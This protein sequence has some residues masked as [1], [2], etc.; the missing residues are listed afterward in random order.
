MTIFVPLMCTFHKTSQVYLTVL[1]KYMNC[2][3]KLNGEKIE[4]DKIK[5]CIVFE[6][7]WNS[8]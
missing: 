3:V 8:R 5:I 7:E 6:Y 2:N 1:H 4:F